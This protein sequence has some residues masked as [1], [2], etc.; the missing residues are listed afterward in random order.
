[1]VVVIVIVVVPLLLVARWITFLDDPKCS[2]DYATITLQLCRQKN[3]LCF[4]TIT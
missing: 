2:V 1:M 4:I 3:A